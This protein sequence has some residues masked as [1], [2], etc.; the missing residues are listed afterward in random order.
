V[1]DRE[2]ADAALLAVIDQ[3]CAE[4]HAELRL[5]HQIHA[6]RNMGRA[7]D[8]PGRPD[9]RAQPPAERINHAQPAGR[10]SGGLG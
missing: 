6:G 5:G 10:A 3:I 8:A 4:V 7:V 1:S 2:L 9:R